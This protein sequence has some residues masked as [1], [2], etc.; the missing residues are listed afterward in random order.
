MFKTWIFPARCRFQGV[1]RERRRA[2]V[3]TRPGGAVAATEN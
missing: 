2:A 3:A 1:V